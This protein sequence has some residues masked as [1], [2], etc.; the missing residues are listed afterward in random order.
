M[1]TW[2][3]RQPGLEQMREEL[4]AKVSKHEPGGRIGPIAARDRAQRV[5]EVSSHAP[6]TGR[7]L[8]QLD[9]DV[10]F[11]DG[12]IEKEMRCFSISEASPNAAAFIL[13]AGIWSVVGLVLLLKRR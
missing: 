5:L 12:L 6:L 3:F 7:C 11:C 4:I 13:C 1:P 10:L 2:A 9:L 8:T